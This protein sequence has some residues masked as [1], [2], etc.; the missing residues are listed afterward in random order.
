MEFATKEEHQ[1][2]A[3]VAAVTG[4]GQTLSIGDLEAYVGARAAQQRV[5]GGLAALVARLG[6]SVYYTPSGLPTLPERLVTMRWL[7]VNGRSV[8]LSPIGRAVL[9]ALDAAAVEAETPITVAL[10]AENPIA[11]PL[12]MQRIAGFDDA[13]LIDP[14]FKLDY[15]LHLVQQ[16]KVTQLLVGPRAD[17][18]GLAMALATVPEDRKLEIRISD[19]V[20]DRAVV[21]LPAGPVDLLGTSLSGLGGRKPSTVVRLEGTTAGPVRLMNLKLW[22][23]ATKIEPSPPQKPSSKPRPAGKKKTVTRERGRSKAQ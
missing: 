23:G 15:F 5:S 2:L 17:T 6:A 1:T 14:Y 11:Y 8:A 13:M 16:T 9:A 19:G 18:N 12:V 10:G 22:D 21:A 3:Y 4:H 20:H 7:A